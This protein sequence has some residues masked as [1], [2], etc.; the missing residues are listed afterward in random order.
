MELRVEVTLW[1]VV[2]KENIVIDCIPYMEGELIAYGVVT[3]P[4]YGNIQVLNLFNRE[5][6]D[7]DIEGLVLET[8]TQKVTWNSMLNAN[9]SQI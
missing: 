9:R 4:V 8:Q 2:A 1:K 3:D 6:K 7:F 5:I